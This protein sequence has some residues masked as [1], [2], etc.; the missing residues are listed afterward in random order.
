VRV[1][2]VVLLVLGAC[3]EMQPPPPCGIERGVAL[4]LRDGGVADIIDVGP[5]SPLTQTGCQTGEKC[6]WV[7]DA[8]IPLYVGHVGC[9]PDGTKN[10]GE[11]CTYGAAGATGY[12]NCFRGGVCSTFE[13]P[14][15]QGTC[16]QVCDNAGGTPMCDA[17]H[18]CVTYPRLF[19]TGA[20][21][22]PAAGICDQRCDPLADNDFDGSGSALDRTGSGCGSDPQ[23]GCYGLPRGSPPETAFTC[24]AERNY[25]R[26][27]RHRS[28]CTQATGCADTND[29]IYVN[30]CNQGYLPV[31]RES[32]AVSTAICVAMCAPLDCYAGHCGSNDENRLGAAPHR[33]MPPDA[34]GNF[35]SDEECQYLWREELDGSGHLLRSPYSDTVG[36]CLDH[37]Q[38]L[39]DPAGGSDLT[40]PLPS[41]KDLPLDGSGSALDA[42]DLGCVSTAT[43]GSNLMRARPAL[44]RMLYHRV[45]Q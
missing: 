3:S 25:G 41:C 9:V 14:G 8:T 30:S 13:T 36:F 43:A 6:T 15:V 16:K 45:M 4:C 32:T 7:I 10:I 22:P 34:V 27:L 2:V 42:V 29:V 31:L 12:D 28:E 21:S 38:Y 1:V 35:G 5:C 23:I 11:P 40:T 33:C 18:A 19:S 39:Y 37:S 20:T 24:M 17:T 44:P 26:A